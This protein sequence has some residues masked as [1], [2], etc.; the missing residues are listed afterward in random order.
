[1]PGYDARIVDEHD[2]PVALGMG[3]LLIKGDSTCAYYWNQPE[4]TKQTIRANDCTG[5]KYYRDADGY[6][7]MAAA[8]T[9]C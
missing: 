9:T 5:D 4:K 8:A 3:N 1:V 2:Q 7:C 6:Y